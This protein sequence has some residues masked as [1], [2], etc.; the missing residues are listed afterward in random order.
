MKKNIFIGLVIFFVSI[1]GYF[2]YLVLTTR[3]HS[4]FDKATYSSDGLSM[5]ISY[6]Q[7]YKKNRLIFG[8]EDSGALVTFGQYW[9]L[10][11]ND[12]TELTIDNDIDFGGQKVSAGIYRMY[13]VPNKEYWEVSLN[14]EIGQFGY[15]SPNY[16]LDVAKINVPVQR[17]TEVYEQLTS[18]I[19]SRSGQAYLAFYWDDTLVEIPISKKN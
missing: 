19:F 18:K 11:A 3:S 7:P 5:S 4:P 2:S 13:A 14:T 9:R 15:F 8:P 16:E 1:I 10:G 12:A 6:C 17:S